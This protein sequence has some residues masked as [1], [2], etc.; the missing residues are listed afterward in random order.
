MDCTV[1]RPIR[2]RVAG[3]F[4]PQ[5]CHRPRRA[6]RENGGFLRVTAGRYF[7]AKM[8]TKGQFLSVICDQ[9]I[10]FVVVGG[11]G[12]EPATPCVSSIK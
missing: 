9:A 6:E 2:A 12:I 11:T 1:I 5:I 7:V 4:L 10:D 3:P 8:A